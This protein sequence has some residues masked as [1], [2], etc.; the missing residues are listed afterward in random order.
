M[1]NF[2]ADEIRSNPGREPLR[3]V[4]VSLKTWISNNYNIPFTPISKTIIIIYA[5]EIFTVVGAVWKLEHR[6]TMLDMLESLRTCA[7]K[8]Y[9]RDLEGVA[10]YREAFL[11]SIYDC[12]EAKG[13][14]TVERELTAEENER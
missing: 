1:D 6:K 10:A 9:R 13:L 11:D 8:R 7:N 14:E 5:H 4:Y 12:P 3:K 2:V